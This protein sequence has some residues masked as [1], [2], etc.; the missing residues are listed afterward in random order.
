MKIT[1]AQLKRRL[2][3]GTKYTAEFIGVNRRFC[4]PGMEV[5]RRIVSKQ[6]SE[7][8]SI[9]LDGPLHGRNIYMKWAGTTA[10]EREGSI[11]VSGMDEFGTPDE[12]LK[13]TI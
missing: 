1:I 10:D 3:V 5:T 8:V 2:P 11:Y 13:I 12:F 7:M 4:K 9:L 6:T